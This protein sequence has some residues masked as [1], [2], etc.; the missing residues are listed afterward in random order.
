MAHRENIY[1][2]LR[3]PA[4]PGHAPNR[5]LGLITVETRVFWPPDAG[6]LHKVSDMVDKA[7]AQVRAQL[8]EHEQKELD[9]PY[10]IAIDQHEVRPGDMAVSRKVPNAPAWRVAWI[11]LNREQVI[12]TG[13]VGDSAPMPAHEF[14]YSREI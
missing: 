5:R 8:K 11:D 13:W 4:N 2:S 1:V 3:V 12:L 10:R 9:R 7:H 6:N 14:L